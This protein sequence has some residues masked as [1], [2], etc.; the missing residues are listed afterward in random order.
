MP[1]LARRV[2]WRIRDWGRGLWIIRR[3]RR[4]WWTRRMAANDGVC[5]VDIASNAVGFFGQMNWCL[6]ICQYCEAHGLVP[7]IRLTGDIYLDRRRG[8]NWLDHYFDWTSPIGAEEIARRVRYT[9]KIAD[10]Q[11]MGPPIAP[12]M[13]VE[14]G[15]RVLRKYL[16]P[17]PH[18][19]ARVEDFLGGLGVAGEIV[20]MHFRG[21]DKPH[22]APRVSWQH[23]LD[24]LRAHLRAHRSVRAVLV[25]SDEQAFIDFMRAA[26]LDVPVYSHADHIRSASGKPVH[27]EPGNGY[28]KGED[29]LVNA[30]L[31]SKCATVIRTTSFLSAWASIF[32]PDLKVVLLNKPYANRLWFP[33]R[34]ILARRDTE[35]APETLPQRTPPMA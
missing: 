10:F 23:C 18:I 33:E 12:A 9:R 30:L 34:E 22:E 32:N 2:G 20:G 17:K 16:R 1:S 11:E 19:A 21:T 14:D 15:A 5:S 26:A 6:F 4:L 8:P 29:A 25:A 27:M 7:D 13:S 31:L 35:Y 28:E 3:S 24:V